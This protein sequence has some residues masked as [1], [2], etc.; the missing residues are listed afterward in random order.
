MAATKKIPTP[1]TP[2]IDI[3]KLG[4]IILTAAILTKGTN[5]A[6]AVENGKAIMEMINA[7]RTK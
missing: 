3:D 6:T 5:V 2:S 1:T 4:Q 7:S